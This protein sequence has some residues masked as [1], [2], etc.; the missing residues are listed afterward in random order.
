MTPRSVSGS[1]KKLIND[2]FVEKVGAN[3]VAYGL[4]ELGKSY[5]FDKE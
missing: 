3:P 4:T 2:G 5:E 1:L